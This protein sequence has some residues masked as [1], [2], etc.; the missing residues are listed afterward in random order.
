MPGMHCDHCGSYR[1]YGQPIVAVRIIDGRLTAAVEREGTPERVHGPEPVGR[2]HVG[3]FE[4]TRAEDD[5]M[6]SE[7]AHSA[8]GARLSVE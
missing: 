4:A 5:R 8:A 1:F 6:P 7:L 2:W 3:C